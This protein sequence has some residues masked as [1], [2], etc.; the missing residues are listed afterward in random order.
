MLPEYTMELAY[1]AVE[2]FTNF[3][4]V[5]DHEMHVMVGVKIG[6]T[7]I[8]I[9][10]VSLCSL[11]K[12]GQGGMLK[13]QWRQTEIL[14]DVKSYIVDVI[15][16]KDIDD[17]V[18]G[19][20]PHEDRITIRYN[21]TES[22]TL[23]A[24]PETL[25]E[26]ASPQLDVGSVTDSARLAKAEFEGLIRAARSKVRESTSAATDKA[27]RPSEIPGALLYMAMAGLCASDEALRATA[28]T[29]LGEVEAFA[30]LDPDNRPPRVDGTL[31][32]ETCRQ[33]GD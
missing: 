32:S 6:E 30:K 12:R 17:I 31:S 2:T 28:Y 13:E 15:A 7:C 29:L 10:P 25:P 22:L 5:G 1:E 11:Q 26:G 19:T 14:P 24:R 21:S 20:G 27:L 3:M 33:K 8:Q 23:I 4:L 16:F 18:S 9:G